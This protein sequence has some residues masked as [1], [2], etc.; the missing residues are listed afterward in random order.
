[1]APWCPGYYISICA[2]SFFLHPDFGSIPS[3][4]CKCKYKYLIVD[5]GPYPYPQVQVLHTGTPGFGSVSWGDNLAD[6]VCRPG[7]AACTSRLHCI[8]GYSSRPCSDS[9]RRARSSGRMSCHPPVARQSAAAGCSVDRVDSPPGRP[10]PSSG[11]PSQAALAAVRLLAAIRRRR[12]VVGMRRS[13]LLED[14]HHRG[15]EGCGFQVPS[16]APSW[17]STPRSGPC[18]PILRPALAAWRLSV[19]GTSSC[20]VRGSLRSGVA[21]RVSREAARR[22]NRGVSMRRWRLFASASRGEAARKAGR[23]PWDLGY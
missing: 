2:P 20:R 15:C 6:C 14:V 8:L 12:C 16:E 11:A 3:R 21:R 23:W 19:R 4:P 18:P 10:V 22:R 7:A 17:P 13:G 5:T 1:M 9:D